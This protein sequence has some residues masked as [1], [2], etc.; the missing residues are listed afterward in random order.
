M[1]YKNIDDR[2]ANSKNYY[3]INKENIKEKKRLYRLNN[4]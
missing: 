2:I 3:L 4:K 1:P